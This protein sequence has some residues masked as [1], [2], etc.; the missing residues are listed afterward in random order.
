MKNRIIDTFKFIAWFIKSA[1][2]VIMM[3]AFSPIILLVWLFTG[4]NFLELISDE[5]NK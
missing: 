5:I 1:I 2:L 4:F 3:V